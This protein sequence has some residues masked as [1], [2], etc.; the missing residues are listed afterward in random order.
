[1]ALDCSLD[2]FGMVALVRICFR[3]GLCFIVQVLFVIV[4]CSNCSAMVDDRFVWW[5]N[6][7]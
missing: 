2:G 7:S 5:R 3:K 6:N 4:G 1:M